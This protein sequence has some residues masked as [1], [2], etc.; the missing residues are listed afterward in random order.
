MAIET[1]ECAADGC[2]DPCPMAH[3]MCIRHWRMVPKPLRDE[4]WAAVHEYRWHGA[5]GRRSMHNC[6]RLALAHDMAIAAV[7]EKEL[8]RA[9]A[10]GR[11]QSTLSL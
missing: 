6:K 1:H 2:T 5:A 4:I 8:R 11:G 3:F 7:L 10:R 9:V